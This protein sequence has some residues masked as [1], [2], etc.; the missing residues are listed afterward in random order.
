MKKQFIEPEIEVL[1]IHTE[2][3]MDISNLPGEELS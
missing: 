2:S 1:E 3:I